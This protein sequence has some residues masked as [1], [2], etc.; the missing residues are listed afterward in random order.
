[1][2]LRRQLRKKFCRFQEKFYTLFATVATSCSLVQAAPLTGLVVDQDHRPLSNV[3]IDFVPAR[4]EFQLPQDLTPKASVLS[5]ADGTFVVPV[6]PSDDLCIIAYAPGFRRTRFAFVDVPKP[7]QK[8]GITLERGE[9]IEGVVLDAQTAAPVGGAEIG[10]VVLSPDEEI[11][12]SKKHVPVWTKSTVTGR[13]VIDGLLPKRTFQFLVR[14]DGYQLANVQ[15]RAGTPN[16]VVRMEKGGFEVRGVV[17]SLSQPPAQFA[18][19]RLWLNGNGFSYHQ[20]ADEHGRFHYRGLP[21]GNFSLE[22]LVAHPR[23]SRVALLEFP[24]DHGKEVELLVSEGYWLEGTTYDATT[25]APVAGVALR[26]ED[27][28]TTSGPHGRF[29]VG[30]L[31]LV[32]SPTIEVLEDAGFVSAQPPAG[33]LVVHNEADG[34]RNLSDETVWVR[35]V[36]R[37][38]L[39]VEGIELTTQPVQL[40]FVPIEGPRLAEHVTSTAYVLRLRSEKAGVIWCTDHATW[41]TAYRYLPPAGSKHDLLRLRLEPAGSLRGHVRREGLGAATSATLC[42]VRL[43]AKIPSADK[44]PIVLE[45]NTDEKGA[46]RFPCVPMGAYRVVATSAKGNIEKA[47]E[48]EIHPASHYQL[49][50]LLPAGKRFAGKVRDAKEQSLGG[51]AVR[52]YVRE[53]DGSTKAGMVETNPEGQFSV[54]ELDGEALSFVQVERKGYVTWQKRDIPLPCENLEIVLTPE[55]ALPFVV[56]GSPSELWQV[57]LMRLDNWGSGT[58]ANQL[59]GREVAS[60]RVVG[61]NQDAFP[62]PDA[63]R[64]RIV[65]CDSKNQL[66]GVSPELEWDP[67]KGVSAPVVVTPGKTGRLKIEFDNAHVENGELVATNMIVPESIVAAER[68]LPEVTGNS[69]ELDD[70]IP[71][72]YLITVTSSSFNSSATNVRVEPDRTATVKL[73]ALQLGAIEG[74]VMNGKAP[75]QG[76]QV[77]LK[78]QTD[79]S[80]EPKMMTTDADGRFRVEGIP[81]DLYI[82]EVIVTGEDGTAKPFRKSAKV[83]GEGGPANAEINIAP[84]PRLSFA[85]PAS[86]NVAPGSPVILLSR[87]SGETVRPQWKA[88]LLEAEVEPGIYTVSVG[89]APVGT[90]RIHADGR[91]EALE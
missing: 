55:T 88:D 40:V 13:F 3:Q 85:L 72:D 67:T 53:T 10:P 73:K 29:R 8:I 33:A 65:A 51:V 6:E 42:T 68:R 44:A 59:I 83:M 54:E 5:N 84:P 89:D 26:V 79:P 76:V 77:T 90:I 46:F 41:A 80:F 16:V 49:D 50:F 12:L 43:Y 69:V 2:M 39:N 19:T 20:C 25:S 82:V 47:T 14:K 81:P 70:L 71:G 48:L 1:M 38:L 61:G 17:R 23:V 62:S 35:P 24:R 60:A 57:Y 86:F 91:T 45:T 21:A 74:R 34:F 56:N 36:R 22:A 63:G 52:Y 28:L 9:K 64:Y 18:G 32:G 31:W 66:V 75:V 4:A 27:K 7:F 58:Y 30:P 15:A 37:L 87:D 11:S 78:S